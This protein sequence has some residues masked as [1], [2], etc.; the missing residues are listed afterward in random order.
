MFIKK[1]FLFFCPI[2][3][4]LSKK[5]TL[6]TVPYLYRAVDSE[7]NTLDWFLSETRDQEAATIFFKKIFGNAHCLQ[8]RVVNVD[9][10]A[11]YPPAFEACKQSEIFSQNTKLRQTKYLNNTIEQDHRFTKRRVAYSQ[12]L[13]SFITAKATIAGYETMHMIRKGQVKDVGKEDVII[14][15]KFI[16][17]LFG[18]AA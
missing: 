7:G 15:I 3:E 1:T 18:I 17:E 12:W 2:K 13:Q 11:A 10:I 16:E 4:D 14:Q 6:L 5:F 9:K 8:P